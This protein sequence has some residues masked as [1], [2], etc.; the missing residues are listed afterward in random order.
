M[1]GKAAVIGR[2]DLIH[3][4]FVN[5]LPGEQACNRS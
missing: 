3:H 1:N 2:F 5:V 4:R